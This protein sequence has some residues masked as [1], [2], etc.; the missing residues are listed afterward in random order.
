MT[1]AWWPD[2]MVFGE[3]EN[4]HMSGTIENLKQVE[5]VVKAAMSS[6]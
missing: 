3:D 6:R 2:W 5:T 1:V 4:L